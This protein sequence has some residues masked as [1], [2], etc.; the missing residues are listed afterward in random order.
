MQ[1]AARRANRA[2]LSPKNLAAA[3]K[4]VDARLKAA[5]RRHE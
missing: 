1:L 2:G 4:R 5:E 3:I